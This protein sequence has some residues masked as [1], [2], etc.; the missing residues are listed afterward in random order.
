MGIQMATRITANDTDWIAERGV[1]PS[2]RILKYV[3]TQLEL[4]C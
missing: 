2:Q 4:R 1:A 3:N